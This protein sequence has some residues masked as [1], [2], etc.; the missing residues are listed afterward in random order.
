MRTNPQYRIVRAGLVA[1]QR[2]YFEGSA[3]CP[4][5]RYRSARILLKIVDKEPEAVTRALAR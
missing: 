3:V 1:R 2:K 5:Q 4:R